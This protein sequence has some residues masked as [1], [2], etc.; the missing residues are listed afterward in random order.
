MA[1]RQTLRHPVSIR[2]VNL[3][4]SAK[5]AAA[6]RA[7]GLLQVPF[8]RAHPHHFSGAGDF[9]SFGYR[10]LRF[11]TFWSSH[12]SIFSDKRTANINL[13]PFRRKRFF[14]NNFSPTG[15]YDPTFGPGQ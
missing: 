2:R 11:N 6:L 8:A 5:L 15:D 1:E 7:F 9:E 12:I 13:R 4:G 3:F 14:E 10:L